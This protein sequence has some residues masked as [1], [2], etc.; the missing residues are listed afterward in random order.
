VPGVGLLASNAGVKCEAPP[1]LLPPGPLAN[2][3]QDD[4]TSSPATAAH[5]TIFFTDSPPL[6]V[7]ASP[8]TDAPEKLIRFCP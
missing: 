5:E 4:A 1:P 6:I 2:T 7:G 3:P 8:L